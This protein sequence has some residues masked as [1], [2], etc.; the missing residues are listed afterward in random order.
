MRLPRVEN[1]CLA[2]GGGGVGAASGGGVPGGRGSGGGGGG[3]AKGKKKVGE[4]LLETVW[5][6]ESW[7]TQ[8]SSLYSKPR[9]WHSR[10][11]ST[12]SSH[13]KEVWMGSKFS[14]RDSGDMASEP[15]VLE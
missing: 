11:C 4:G 15:Q 3:P 9:P 5:T 1:Y 6:L 12:H 8:V 13:M 2:R 14:H 7:R 10:S